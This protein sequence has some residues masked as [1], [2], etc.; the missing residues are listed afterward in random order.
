MRHISLPLARI[1]FRYS[2]NGLLSLSGS[3][4]V[5]AHAGRP[6]C[7]TINSDHKFK[8]CDICNTLDLLTSHPCLS[9]DMPGNDVEYKA[10]CPYPKFT[11]KAYNSTFNQA[12]TSEPEIGNKDRKALARDT[13]QKNGIADQVVFVC[14]KYGSKYGAEYV[15]N[16]FISLKKSTIGYYSKSTDKSRKDH[17]RLVCYTDDPSGVIDEVEVRVIPHRSLGLSQ[18]SLIQRG[19]K[20]K[21]I[22]PLLSTPLVQGGIDIDSHSHHVNLTTRA[23]AISASH[24][25]TD[26]NT[27]IIDRSV[28][29]KGMMNW[30]GW[31]LKAYLFYAVNDLEISYKFESKI[32]SNPPQHTMLPRDKKGNENDSGD[33]REENE[34]RSEIGLG[35]NQTEMIGIESKGVT[36]QDRDDKVELKSERVVEEKG[37]VED[38][39]DDDES[40]QT[41][42]A[43]W[44]C[45]MD[46][47]TVIKGPL[48]FLFDTLLNSSPSSPPISSPSSLSISSPFSLPIS[49]PSSLP[50]SSPP[51]PPFIPLPSSPDSSSSIGVSAISPEVEEAKLFY[52][53]GAAHFESEGRPCGINSSIMIWKTSPR[54]RLKIFEKCDET[55][56]SEGGRGR[57]ED[58]TQGDEDGAR[59]RGEEEKEEE[60][61]ARMRE[62][63]EKGEGEVNGRKVE[64]KAKSVQSI[65]VSNVDWGHNGLQQIFTYLLDNYESVTGCVYKFD[66]YLEMMLL[67]CMSDPVFIE[68]ESETPCSDHTRVMSPSLCHR[69][70][71]NDTENTK[72]SDNEVKSKNEHHNVSRNDDENQYDESND[73]SESSNNKQKERNSCPMPGKDEIVKVLYLQDL[74]HCKER[75]VDFSSL[76]TATPANSSS[77]SPSE[78]LLTSSPHPSRTNCSTSSDSDDYLSEKQMKLRDDAQP[79]RTYEG[80]HIHH[81]LFTSASIICFPLKP[82]PHEVALK[83]E[84]MKDL[85][86]GRW[87]ED[88]SSGS[89]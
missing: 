75:I 30:S 49:S 40:H 27:S 11:E 55:L 31:W 42:D 8:D 28:L 14:V 76:L 74:T 24:E 2:Q 72:E 79:L 20:D 87:D 9:V 64:T 57:K 38:R 23:A 16:L 86:E 88:N 1:E 89:P 5:E 45:Y 44:V 22:T 59:M 26:L 66:H 36:L 46:L 48:D 13:E 77:H 68:K 53:L 18:S 32:H 71:R 51:L 41:S 63:E 6:T 52:T 54:S 56:Q 34:F 73:M 10:S 62:E 33:V 15:N 84:W 17:F 83:E 81:N 37:E 19:R 43:L 82:K 7:T 78:S 85:W 29:A 35:L 60:N 67:N 39:D 69:A 50:I 58:K 3:K 65:S 12:L 80:L 21:L 4:F 47:D 25:R 70:R 61:G